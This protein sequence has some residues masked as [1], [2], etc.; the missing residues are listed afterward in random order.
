MVKDKIMTRAFIFPGQGSQNIGMGKDIFLKSEVGRELFYKIDE[1]LD[2]KLTDII[3][4]GP[5]TELTLTKNAQP[6]IMA[7]SLAILEVIF[8]KLNKPIWEICDIVA[9]HSLGEYT[10]LY[11]A[12]SISLKDTTKL[13][14]IRGN[15][16]NDAAA[17][18]AGAMA[19]CIGIDYNQLQNII[20]D[21]SSKKGG[22]C[23]IANYN[24]ANQIVISGH[25]FLV[26]DIISELKQSNYKAILLNVSGAF[27]SDL[28]KPAERIMH[29]TLQGIDFSIP[30]VPIISNTTAIE[31]KNIAAIKTNLVKQMCSTVKWKDTIDRLIKLGIQEI[32][33]IG[34]GA[35]L[36]NLITKSGYNI[37]TRNIANMENI[38]EFCDDL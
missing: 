21:I 6:A 16:M 23:Q 22:I 27:H 3:F 36:S 14:R 37:K 29:D 7:V 20:K 28:M 18:N 13:L 15:A 1:I 4:D 17:N 31:T 30:S 10:A 24:S 33:E 2:I 34:H 12:Q 5:I 11:A 38:L 35:V 26:Q 32:V 8:N 25:K 19:A 9:G